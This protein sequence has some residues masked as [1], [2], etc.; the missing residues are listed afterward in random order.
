MGGQQAG[1]S[2]TIPDLFNGVCKQDASATAGR[3]VCNSMIFFV[4]HCTAGFSSTEAF[5]DSLRPQ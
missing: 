1:M 2:C 4:F 5:V 3:N